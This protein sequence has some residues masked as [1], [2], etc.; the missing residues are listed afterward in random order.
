MNKTG[1]LV[2]M[3]NG[4]KMIIPKPAQYFTI[5]EKHHI[6]QEYLSSSITKNEIWKKYTG[7]KDHGRLLEWMGKLGYEQNICQEKTIF[8]GKQA[9][10]SPDQKLPS[11]QTIQEKQPSSQEQQTR[12]KA[13]EYELKLA[14]HKL[15]LAQ[16][17]L[18]AAKK[19]LE[20]AQIKA[21][22]YSTMIDLAEKEFNI[23]IRK[24]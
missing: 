11:D 5:S 9:A 4:E 8:T 1:K 7:K 12:L 18:G 21:I 3:A 2:P 22:A 10:M 20:L 13:L 14:Q 16:K 15:A 23:P 24:K 19:D 17:E 6:I